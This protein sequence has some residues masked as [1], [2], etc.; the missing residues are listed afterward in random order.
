MGIAIG[1]IFYGTEGYLE[2]QSW[3]KSG[4]EWQAFRKREKVPFAGTQTGVG[5]QIAP[6]LLG[7]EST[8][9]FINFI[10]AVRAGKDDML[11]SDIAEGFHSAALPLLGNISYRLGR[12]LKFNG[13]E[14]KFINDPEADIL[15]SRNYRKPFVVP[16][17][18]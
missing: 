5:N 1:N 7:P 4:G 6:T 14:E 15:L 8:D 2:L 12:E 3:E 18:I 16:E 9:H 10:K 17:N 13:D 11:N